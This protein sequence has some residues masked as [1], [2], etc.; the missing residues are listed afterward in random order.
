[1]LT[2][3]SKIDEL[4][5]SHGVDSKRTCPSLI[6]SNMSG[7]RTTIDVVATMNARFPAILAATH[8]FSLQYIPPA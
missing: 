2:C 8:D 3:F 4:A 6:I 5:V 1:M 7:I